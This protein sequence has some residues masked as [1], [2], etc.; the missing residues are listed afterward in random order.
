MNKKVKLLVAVLCVMFVVLAGCG[1]NGKSEK[2]ASKN[3]SKDFAELTEVYFE[4][5]QALMMKQAEGQSAD[6]EEVSQHAKDV[7]DSKEYKE[8]KQEAD[9]VDKFE[10]SKDDKDA[11]QITELQAALK[12]YNKVQSDYFN[13]LAEA[14]DQDSYNQ[15][16]DE[17]AS[18]LND[19]Q[20][21]FIEI[22]NNIEE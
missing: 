13:K 21:K 14:K 6:F 15:V 4:K 17:L 22:M 19:S 7:V 18:Q 20:D 10:L 3:T 2:A 12:D 11:K 16:N 8:W 1:S 9:K 5:Q